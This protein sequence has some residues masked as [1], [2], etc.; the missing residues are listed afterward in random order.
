MENKNITD[1]LT[2]IS[3]SYYTK[4]INIVKELENLQDSKIYIYGSFVNNLMKEPF[5][6]PEC[7]YELYS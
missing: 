7:V 5:D 2:L 3:K 1:Y 4:V 6:L